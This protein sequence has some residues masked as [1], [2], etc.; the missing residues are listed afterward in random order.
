MIYWSK[1]YARLHVS[2]DTFFHMGL[3]MDL[4]YIDICRKG[5]STSLEG[6]FVYSLS[7]VNECTFQS[8][9]SAIEKFATF[10]TNHQNSDFPNSIETPKFLWNVFAK[11][12]IVFKEPWR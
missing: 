11:L 1:I 12:N 10:E 7:Y 3:H 2:I 9:T 8:L 5:I 6:N 4:K